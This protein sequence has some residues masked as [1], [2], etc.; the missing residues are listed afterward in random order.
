MSGTALLVD[1]DSDNNLDI[2]LSGD[3]SGASA[4]IYTA[5]LA[6]D[7][8]APSAPTSFANSYGDSLDINW[9]GATDTE[10]GTLYYNLRVG[11]SSGANDIVSRVYGSASNPSQGMFGNMLTGDN[12]QLNISKGTY[13]WAVQTIDSSFTASD[14]SAEQT[15]VPTTYISSCQNLDS[16]SETYRLTQDIENE[17]GCFD[18]QAND[19]I[20]DCQG[21]QIQGDGTSST[22]AGINITGRTNII[23]RN[24]T[25]LNFSY[26]DIELNIKNHNLCISI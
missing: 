10:G 15:Y 2:V 20:L 19:I 21:H 16:E 4:E 9:S 5:E 25:I 26:G 8:T 24:C 3:E 14:W 22:Y 6:S 23:V 18:I 1:V 12:I 13:Y 11:T 17:T 7:N